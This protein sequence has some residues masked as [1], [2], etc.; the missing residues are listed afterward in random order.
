MPL[1]GS[2]RELDVHTLR[3]RP[4]SGSVR[5][6]SPTTGAVTS[7]FTNFQGAIDEA[8][9]GG[10]SGTFTIPPDTMGAVGLDKVITVLTTTSWSRTKLPAL[11]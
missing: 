11:F 10:P 6:R 8:V 4:G 1:P 3:L 2:I 9:G 5:Q 7:P